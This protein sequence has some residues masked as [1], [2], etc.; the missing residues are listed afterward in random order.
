M[1]CSIQGEPV[2]ADDSELR[3]AVYLDNFNATLRRL[4]HTS[5]TELQINEPNGVYCPA[6]ASTPIAVRQG[7]F[8]VGSNRT[9]RHAQEPCPMGSYCEDG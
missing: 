6:G 9:T 7:Y 3:S 2:I 8:S 5:R 1:C 4:P